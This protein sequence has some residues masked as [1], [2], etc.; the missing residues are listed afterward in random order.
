M[1]SVLKKWLFV[2]SAITSRVVFVLSAA[3]DGLA[4]TSAV[5]TPLR[6]ATGTLVADTAAF[7]HVIGLRLL[8]WGDGTTRGSFPAGCS[9]WANCTP[10]SV[11]PC[12][13]TNPP[14]GKAGTTPGGNLI[15]DRNIH[16]AG[17]PEGSPA[18][19]MAAKC[20]SERC[21]SR[22]ELISCRRLFAVVASANPG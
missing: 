20:E 17:A 12:T 4:K 9:I 2:G 7:L 22:N 13:G 11:G 10:S 15:I 21:F 14:F 16:G 6:L 8:V 3:G 1:Q 5:A 19:A 18:I